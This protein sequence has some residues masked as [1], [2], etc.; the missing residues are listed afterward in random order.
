MLTIAP[1]LK[2]TYPNKE[3]MVCTYVWQ[4]R[5]WGVLMQE[6]RVVAYES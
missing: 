1:I 4:E 6:G 2:V 3:F 5:A